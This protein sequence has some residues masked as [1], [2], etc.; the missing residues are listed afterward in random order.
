M[1]PIQYQAAIAAHQLLKLHDEQR[2]LNRHVAHLAPRTQQH[3]ERSL[4]HLAPR[5]QQHLERSSSRMA[6]PFRVKHLS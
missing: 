6:N 3:L 2:Q 5:T 1:T 4:K